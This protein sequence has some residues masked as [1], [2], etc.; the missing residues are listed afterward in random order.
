MDAFAQAGKQ[1]LK[2]VEQADRWDVETLHSDG[3][4]QG[5]IEYTVWSEVFSC[6]ECA[7]EV[8][9]LDEALDDDTKRVRDSFPCPHCNAGLT[10]KKLERLYITKL[11]SAT[12]TTL[13]RPSACPA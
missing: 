6:P 4:N 12:G 13:K 1:L 9:F 2:A 7:G 3:K 10:K 5:R 8:N 11:D